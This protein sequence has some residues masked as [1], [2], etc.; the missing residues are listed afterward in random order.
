MMT[1]VLRGASKVA[2]MFLFHAHQAGTGKSHL[3][4][5]IATIATGRPCPVITYTDETEMEKRLGALILEGAGIISLDNCSSDLGGDLLAQ[6]TE[7]QLVRV[8]ILGKSEAPQCEW[9][10]TM[11]ATGNNIGFKADMTRRGLVSNLDARMER[12]ENRQFCSDPIAK[13]AND[14]GAYVAAVL[15]IA[16]AYRVAGAPD[17]CD[18]FASY[19]QWSVAVRAPLIWLG[20]EDPKVSQEAAT[21]L[22]GFRH[23]RWLVAIASAG[24]WPAPRCRAP[25]P[26]PPGDPPLR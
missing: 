5:V 19:E 18:N 26:W 3:V 22:S 15:T 8:R 13:V 17:V 14:R 4:N 24:S 21:G 7:Q 11:F 20:L 10:G 1:P 23:S 16:H 25:W 12:P 2:P 6:V 9:R